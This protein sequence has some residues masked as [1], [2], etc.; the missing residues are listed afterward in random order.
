MRDFTLANVLIAA[1][2]AAVGAPVLFR[3]ARRRG[4][5]R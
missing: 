3:L 2:A 4:W 1:A 5:F